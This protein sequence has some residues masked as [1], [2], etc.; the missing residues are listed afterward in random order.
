MTRSR[1]QLTLASTALLLLLA[2]IFPGGLALAADKSVDQGTVTYRL[3]Y[4]GMGAMT[5]MLPKQETVYFSGDRL[6][7]DSGMQKTLVDRKAGLVTNFM[8]LGETKVA[9]QYPEG[10]ESESEYEYEY[11]GETRDFSGVSAERVDIVDPSDPN[12]RLSVWMTRGFSAEYSHYSGLEGFALE[13]TIFLGDGE[14]RSVA[15][16]VE[17]A[18]VDQALFEIPK[19]YEL[20]VLESQEDLP[21]K[22]QELAGGAQVITGGSR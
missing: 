7:I 9:L 13:S 15:E 2:S 22:M 3:S 18:P 12:N 17:L 5:A 14:R 21:G 11:S 1:Q 16:K 4:E 20:I 10:E 6:M 19:G 8:D